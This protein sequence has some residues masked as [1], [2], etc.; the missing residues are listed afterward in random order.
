M[1]GNNSPWAYPPYCSPF[2][3]VE[4]DSGI[5]Q[6]SKVLAVTLEQNKKMD[7]T[8]LSF[9]NSGFTTVWL[10]PL[11]FVLCPWGQLSSSTGPY[12][13]PQSLQC[14]SVTFLLHTSVYALQ[15][16]R[17][18]HFKKGLFW[19]VTYKA[20]PEREIWAKPH[21]PEP[22]PWPEHFI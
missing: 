16:D 12:S 8:F 15:I 10:I 9:G 19:V 5:S 1:Q 17:T 14:P 3:G 4:I 21:C 11:L 18:L 6:V 22:S 7:Q 20:E 13:I 2:W